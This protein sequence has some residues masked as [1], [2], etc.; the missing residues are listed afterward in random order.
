ML[1][2]HLTAKDFFCSYA[3]SRSIVAPSTNKP[4]TEHRKKKKKSTSF[5]TLLSE[6][7]GVCFGTHKM[8]DSNA[9]LNA[10]E[11]FHLWFDLVS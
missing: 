6:T 4:D 3:F 1:I 7:V 8:N 10:Q 11:Q 5:V 9:K 2:S